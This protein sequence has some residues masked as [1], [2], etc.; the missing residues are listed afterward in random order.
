MHQALLSKRRLADFVSY[1]VSG[2][3]LVAPVPLQDGHFK[4]DEVHSLDEISL[5]YIPTIL[6]PKK[7]FM[8]QRSSLLRY[9]LSKIHEMEE[10]VE[11]EQLVL[12]G[13]HTCDLAG[14]H[15]LN[16]VFSDHP[17]DPHYLARNNFITIIGLECNDY[18]DSSAGCAMLHTHLPKGGYD[19]FLTELSDSYYIHINTQKGEDMVDESSL[20]DDVTRAAEGELNLLRSRKRELFTSEVP[21]RYQDIPR[22]FEETFDSDVWSQL[23]EKCLSCG[24]CTAVCPTCFCFDIVD[25]PELDLSKGERLRVWDSCQN[26]AF[27]TVAG[28]ENFR[29]KRMDRQ[30]HRFHRKFK[31]LMDRY[32]R[33]FCTGCGRCSRSCMAGI[34]LKRTISA[35]IEERG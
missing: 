3:K 24:N 21:I 33:L 16:I 1:L 26:E 13:V 35:L 34:N 8:P 7:Y 9:D 23:G 14:I 6:P 5:K 17:K 32:G 27:A 25:E 30:R 4:F 12:F 18:C 2:H 28:G 22:L 31:Y 11:L 15:C 20:F 19:L 29:R 10:I